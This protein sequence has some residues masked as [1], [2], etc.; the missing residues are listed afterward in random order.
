MHR[1]T[2]DGDGAGN[3]RN[4]LIKAI[5][6][7]GGMPGAIGQCRDGAAHGRIGALMQRSA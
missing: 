1:L 4:R 3:A 6:F 2:L 5:G 7:Q